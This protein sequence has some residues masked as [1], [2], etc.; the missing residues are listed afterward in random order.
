MMTKPQRVLRYFTVHRNLKDGPRA[1]QQ[2]FGISL[3]AFA[4]DFAAYLNAQKVA[5]DL[6][7]TG[8]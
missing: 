2:V 7:K 1:F 6:S 5:D 4:A 3:E 8:E